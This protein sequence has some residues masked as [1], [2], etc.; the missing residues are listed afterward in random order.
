VLVLYSVVFAECLRGAC[1]FQL[2]GRE[3]D[4]WFLPSLLSWLGVGSAS[5]KSN[6]LVESC[7]KDV[8]WY[9]YTSLRASEAAQPDMSLDLWTELQAEMSTSGTVTSEQALSVCC[10]THM[11]ACTLYCMSISDCLP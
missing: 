5:D 6:V 2:T 8:T 1:L 3:R 9:T 11:H 7:A 10:C 4:S